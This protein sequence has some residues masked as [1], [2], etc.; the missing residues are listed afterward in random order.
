MNVFY[1]YEVNDEK[2]DVCWRPSFRLVCL[3]C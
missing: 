1:I 3:A 2:L